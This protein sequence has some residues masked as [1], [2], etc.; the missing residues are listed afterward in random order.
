MKFFIKTLALFFF[1]VS[2]GF[3]EVI[4]RFDIDGLSENNADFIKSYTSVK[5]GD[6]YDEKAIAEEIKKL[7]DTDL[8]YDIISSFKD[9]VLKISFKEN[10]LIENV[11]FTGNKEIDKDTL[12]GETLSG[13]R[14]PLS[15][16]K[17]NVDIQRIIE[18]YARV[19]YLDVKVIPKIKDKGFNRVDL[20]F[21]IDEGK[22]THIKKVNFYGNKYVSSRQLKSVVLTKKKGLS[23]LLSGTDTY[24]YNR[25]QYD[26]ELLRNFYID[27]GYPEFK[28]I[29]IDSEVDPLDSNFTVSYTVHE[30]NRY[31]FGDTSFKATHPKITSEMLKELEEEFKLNN[32]EW[33]SNSQITR[34]ETLIQRRINDYEIQF[35]TVSSNVRLNSYARTVDVEFLISESGRVFVEKINIQGNYKTNEK[36]IRRE[37]TFAEGDSFDQESLSRSRNK[38][39]STQYFGKVDTQLK[40]GSE[41]GKVELDVLLEEQPTGSISL[42]AGYSTLD[43]P[44]VNFGYQDIN[45]AG[46]GELLELSGYIAR[47]KSTLTLRNSDSRFLDRDLYFSPFISVSDTDYQTES[48]YNTRNAGVGFDIAYNIVDRLT[49]SFGYS[50]QTRQIYDVGD[51]ASYYVKQEEG[52]SYI[53]SIT[54]RITYD[55]RDNTFYTKDGYFIRL[56]TTFAGAFGEGTEHYIK[57][58]LTGGVF[59]NFYKELVAS[60]TIDT[61][62]MVNTMNDRSSIL[63]RYYLGSYNFRGFES[64]GIG[65]RDLST[66]DAL[67]GMQYYVVSTELKFPLPFV[68]NYGIIASLFVD[69]GTLTGLDF[70]YNPDIIVDSGSVRMAWGIG[71]SWKSPF[72]QIGFDWGFPIMKESYDETQLFN[73][74]AG[75][76]F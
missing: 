64:A 72:G 41:E 8:F 7:Y 50:Y 28:L 63:D 60:V 3:A 48:S 1:T 18:L 22:K 69:T 38:L 31:K 61:G 56:S 25:I 32:K 29:N 35:Y 26:K 13:S 47:E 15:L 37:F 51:Y 75:T 43:G 2:L 12:Q 4:K 49:Q 16:S 33:F 10:K 9:G 71:I 20:A 76:R 44:S 36:V 62:S 57:N 21:V 23:S 55:K 6:V 73:I 68:D 40:R 53:S 70:D 14:S 30:G 42:G 17:V 39:L 27:Q 54:H 24:D 52:M 19:G 58:N 74:N 34:L 5:E 46:E 67:G 65:P 66:G 59:Y 11:Y 45:F